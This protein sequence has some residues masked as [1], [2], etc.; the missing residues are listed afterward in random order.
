MPF[1]VPTSNVWELCFV[2]ILANAFLLSA[3]FIIPIL[4]CVNWTPMVL[5]CIWASYIFNPLWKTKQNETKTHLP[6]KQWNTVNYH[7]D[8]L[9]SSLQ[10]PTLTSADNSR[11]HFLD[12]DKTEVRFLG[13]IMQENEM[14][15]G[16][17]TSSSSFPAMAITV[18]S[19]LKKPLY[20]FLPGCHQN[21]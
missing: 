5:T 15:V 2:Y 17:T 11:H 16:N 6:T 8:S 10:P 12:G 19:V 4:V 20:L 14:P 9:Q 1:Y 13:E 3:F 18:D 21:Q 7:F